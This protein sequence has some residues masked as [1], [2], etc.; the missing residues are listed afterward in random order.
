[1]EV[2]NGKPG[3]AGTIQCRED[4]SYAV[5]CAI[6]SAWCGG[7]AALRNEFA[8][9]RL[10]VTFNTPWVRYADDETRTLDQDIAE[11]ALK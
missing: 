5:C 1:M 7:L 9:L 3:M 10:Q 8:P 2:G 4:S 11:V 6:G